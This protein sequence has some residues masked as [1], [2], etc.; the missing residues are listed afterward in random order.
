MHAIDEANLSIPSIV[1]ELGFPPER[2]DILT[3]ITGLEFETAWVNRAEP[4]IDEADSLWSA[5]KV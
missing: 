4:T 1:F 3:S 5:C 2:L